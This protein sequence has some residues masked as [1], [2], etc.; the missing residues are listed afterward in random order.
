MNNLFNF[1]G[2]EKET[3]SPTVKLLSHYFHKNAYHL[4]KENLTLKLIY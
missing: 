3:S 1:N 4:F 2:S